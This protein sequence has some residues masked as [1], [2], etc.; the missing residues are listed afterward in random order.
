MATSLAGRLVFIT[1]ASSGFGEA[2]ALGFARA[3]ARCLL[4]ARRLP[5]L[6][7]LASRIA[8]EGGAE[9]RVARLDTTDRKAVEEFVAS[10]PE[11][12]REIDILVNNAGKAVGLGKLHEGNVD[13]W[14][15]MLDTNV[16]GLL[17]VDRAV[18]PGMVARGRGHVIHIGSI[19]GREV[20]PGGA[21]Y[22]GSKAAVDFITKGLRLDVVGAGVRVSTVDPGLA[23]TEFSLVRFKGDA[24]RAKAVYNGLTPL[25]AEDVADAVLYVAT[26]PPHVNVA[27][28]LLL[29]TDQSSAQ[30]VHRA[31]P[32]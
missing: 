7:A 31:P 17:Y 25:T 3:G 28:V 22:C 6:E 11:G 20:Y 30:V 15:E 14:E 10:L 13:D 5:R 32:R 1:G 21:V 9:T 16:K 27:E 4:V 29:P 26:R 12:W 8:A 23:E 19:A 24:A 18:V 2:C